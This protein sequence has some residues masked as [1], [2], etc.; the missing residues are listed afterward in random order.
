MKSNYRKK[1]AQKTGQTGALIICWERWA[2]VP[3]ES[4]DCADTL[5]CVRACKD[6]VCI[7]V[8]QYS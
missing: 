4:L 6:V 8:T 2:I 1:E 5:E 3:P 7:M